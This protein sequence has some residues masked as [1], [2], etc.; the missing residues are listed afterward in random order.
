MRRSGT[1]WRVPVG[2][3]ETT[4][5]W[6][7]A[8]PLPPETVFVCA[9][10]AGGHMEDR[11]IVALRDAFLPRGIGIVRFNFLYRALGSGRPDPMSRLLDCYAAVTA[12][13]LAELQPR[14]L[15]VGGRSLGGRVASMLLAQRA[16]AA[17]LLLLAYPLH[18]PG[19]PEKLR[20]AHL[21]AIR[22]PVLCING[23]RD[24]FCQ[25]PLMERV[26]ARLG[27]NWSMYWLEGADH[28]FHVLKGS[29]RTD[30]EVLGEVAERSCA[31]MT[32]LPSA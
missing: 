15:I 25:R 20:D 29:G 22:Q 23:T 24:A 18:P 16:S 19:Q 1:I 8:G 4:V 28:S 11:S 5:A 13:V 26:L 10:G 27:T 9:H 6:D 32:G 30:H 14:L 3:E 7:P 17:G 31:W 12:R 2:V 21:E